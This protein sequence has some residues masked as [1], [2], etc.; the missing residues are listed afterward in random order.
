MPTAV[1]SERN[2]AA[3]RQLG[4]ATA[5][6]D[7]LDGRGILIGFADYGFDI[8]HPC[9]LDAAGTR[10]RLASLWDQNAT[11]RD[12]PRERPPPGEVADLDRTALDRLLSEARRIGSRGPADAVYD[13]H[14]SYFTRRGVADGAHGT[15]IASI[16]AGTPSAGFSGVAPGADL[17]GVQLALPEHRWKEVDEAGVPSWTGW[18]P[19]AQSVWDGWRSYDESIEILAAL[20]YIHAKAVAFGAPGLVVNLSIGAWAGA[21]DGRSAVERRIM[22]LVAKGEA[23]EGPATAVVVV[24]GNA[25]ADDGHFAATVTSEAPA[26]FAWRMGA[27]DPTQN[28]LEIWYEGPATLDVTLAPVAHAAAGS[29]LGRPSRSC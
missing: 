23:G 18:N 10:A 4:A 6:N 12:G 9:L 14:A 8:L 29:S 11:F 27:D 5:A 22:E 2:E 19:A 25:G 7:G 15:I 3:L 1:P 16:A 17:I 26:S 28:K 13:P 24:A 21:H 20:D